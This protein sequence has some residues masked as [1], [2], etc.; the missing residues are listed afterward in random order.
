MSELSE[1]ILWRY[2]RLSES[3]KP[4]DQTSDKVS[5]SSELIQ[6]RVVKLS[7]SHNLINQKFG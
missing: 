7:E 6:R 2:V 3:H 1:L 5:E 4:T